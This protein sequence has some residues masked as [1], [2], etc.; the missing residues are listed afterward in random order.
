VRTLRRARA[1]LLSA[2]A[3]TPACGA[4]LSAQSTRPGDYALPTRTTG[5]GRP[6]IAVVVRQGDARGAVAVAV[7]TQ[8]IAPDR[9]A[10]VGVALAALVEARLTER[11]ILDA[12][13]LGG[14]DG[15]RMRALVGSAT[16]TAKAIDAIRASMLTPVALD[17]PAAAAVVR[18][19]G[20]LA[21]RPLADPALAD[22]ARCTGEAYAGDPRLPTMT[23]LEAWR[24]AAHGLGRVALATAGDSSIADATASTLAHAPAWPA[25]TPIEPSP[26]P[27]IGSPA[28]VYDASGEVPP[29][30]ARV[31]VTAR[32]ANP[33]RAVAAAAA[34]GDARGPLASRLQALEAPARVRSVV[35]TAHV[36]GGCVSVTMELAGRDLSS[37]GAARIATAAALARQEVGVEI[38]DTTATGDLGRLLATQAPDPRDAAERAAWWS[39]AGRRA[40]AR[41]DQTRL[42]LT[43]GVAASREAPD[44]MPLTNGEA[45]RAAIDRATIAWHSQVVEARSRV[46]RGQGEVWMLLASTCGTAPESSAD[47]GVSAAVAVASAARAQ[48]ASGGEVRVEP[49][50]AAD[51]VGVLAHGASR[52]NESPAAHARRLADVAARAFAAD[53][54]DSRDAARARTALLAHAG[55]SGARTLGALAEAL[56]AGRPSWV[57]A[58]GTLFGLG[59]ASDESIA[60]R[61]SALRGEPLRVAVLANADAAQAEAAA[62]AV[63]RWVARRPNEARLCAPSPSLSAPRPGT[64]AA[65]LPAGAPSEALVAVPLAAGDE[66]GRAAATWVA[67]MLEGTDGLL[68]H[69]LGA[70]RA[71]AGGNAL[72]REWS[73]DVL[74]APR[75]PALVIRVVSADG[76]IDAAVAQTRTLLDRLRQGAIHDEDRDRAAASIARR[77][78]ASSLDPAARTIELWRGGSTSSPAPSIDTLRA[79]A[80]AALRDDALVIVAARPPRG[81]RR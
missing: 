53:A 26:W 57:D 58:T 61:A 6:A 68:A 69:S 36:D 13:V 12:T 74:G 43:V 71:E 63:D 8:G 49:F 32:T 65:D 31:V 79:F 2:T 75:A 54:I 81:T 51:G 39:L 25:S 64:Y 37:D 41:D 38:D 70:A 33:V 3:L 21:R 35:A 19:V 27:A 22:V 29:G 78:L 17:D 62:R 60:A 18:K 44:S 47:A 15:W 9:G 1:L 45:L 11:G 40:G 66:A 50:V 14:W 34:L 7:T 28:S 30:G 76:A 16:E 55:A 59:S 77:A 20:A 4:H 80:G 56:A 10:V 42:A 23:E 46:E 24:R 5:P 52:A 48:E 72:A 67:A 73:A